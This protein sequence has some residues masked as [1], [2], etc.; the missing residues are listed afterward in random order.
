MMPLAAVGVLVIAKSRAAVVYAVGDDF[1]YC[2]VQ[3]CK[4][5]AGQCVGDG[6]RVNLGGE[7]SFVGVD[8]ADAAD[9]FLLQDKL[10]YLQFSFG[11]NILQIRNGKSVA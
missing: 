3:S 4:F 7:Q 9:G 5:R 1:V 8:V 2:V 6:Q 11:A 10:F